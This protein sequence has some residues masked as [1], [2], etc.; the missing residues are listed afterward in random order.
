MTETDSSCDY[1]EYKICHE[2]SVKEI[3]RLR[4]IN[5]DPY[6]YILM[7]LVGYAVGYFL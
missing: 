7:L 1:C 4:G 6:F 3:Q 5:K 2:N